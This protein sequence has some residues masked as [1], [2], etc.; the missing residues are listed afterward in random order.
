MYLRFIRLVVREG[1]ES[2]FQ[3]FYRERVIPTLSEVP[4]CIF[5]GLLTPWR[6][7]E[8]RSLTLWRSEQDAHAYEESGLY[9][10]LLRES[11]PF[12][13]SRTVWRA[14]LAEPELDLDKM[15]TLGPDASRGTLA[16]LETMAPTSAPT[17]AVPAEREIPPEGYVVSAED[18]GEKLSQSPRAVFVRVV[19]IHVR[20]ER[21]KEFDAIYGDRVLPALKEA[22]GCIG[23]FLAEGS[24][25]ANES[26]SITVWEREEAAVRYEMS[27]EYERLVQEIRPTLSPLSQWQLTLGEPDRELRPGAGV[28]TYQLV[29]GRKLSGT[30]GSD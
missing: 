9:Q 18:V 12:L 26:L 20:P 21:R 14:K 23:A 4:G 29:H 5:A 6:S 2:A 22:P 28:A 17:T 10:M 27:E 11:M 13:S 7:E 19:A 25:D 1:E 16:A 3:K 8:H 30:P 24:R 15:A